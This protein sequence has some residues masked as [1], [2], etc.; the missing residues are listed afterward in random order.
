MFTNSVLFSAGGISFTVVKCFLGAGVALVGLSALVFVIL[1]KH[2]HGVVKRM[3]RE[4]AAW[5]HVYGREQYWD[6]IHDP[7]M[8]K[9]VGVTGRTV[10]I[11]FDIDSLR[12]AYRRGDRMTFWLSPILFTCWGVAVWLLLMSGLMA[13]EIPFGFQ[14]A[15][16][17][18]VF[19][20]LL[21]PWFMAWAAVNTN[22]DLGKAG[23]GAA[24]TSQA[25]PGGAPRR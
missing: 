11:T 21:L 25:A 19:L 3:S 1:F 14:I 22:I 7:A 17:A 23:S 20:F 8:V 5:M 6:D 4:E 15:V 2:N 24:A 13:V 16:T 12:N 9:A 18:F 10:E